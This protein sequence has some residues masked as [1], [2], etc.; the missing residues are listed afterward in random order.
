M[1]VSETNNEIKTKLKRSSIFDEDG[2]SNENTTSEV[3]GKSTIL[4]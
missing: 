2:L 3:I 1:L 4:G